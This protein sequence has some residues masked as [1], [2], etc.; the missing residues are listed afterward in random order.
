MIRRRIRLP[1][2]LTWKN[3][4]LTLTLTVIVPVTLKTSH[5]RLPV[6]KRIQTDIGSIPISKHI[7]VAR[8]LRIED[9]VGVGIDAPLAR[10]ANGKRRHLRSRVL[11]R[12]S[13]AAFPRRALLT[14][15]PLPSARMEKRQPVRSVNHAA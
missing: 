15:A 13:R 12:N 10:A 4:L 6:N 1:A 8:R 9:L 14:S 7:N 5:L 11:I 3:R 2:P